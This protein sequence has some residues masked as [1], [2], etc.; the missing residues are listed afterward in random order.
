MPNS[1]V[2]LKIP[3]GNYT[4]SDLEVAIAKELLRIRVKYYVR[5]P[6]HAHVY[7]CSYERSSLSIDLECPPA[8]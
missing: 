8:V 3:K 1:S 4:L 6:L 7:S 2:T 5:S